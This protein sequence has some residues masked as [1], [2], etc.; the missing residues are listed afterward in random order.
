[1]IEVIR[2]HAQYLQAFFYYQSALFSEL[3]WQKGTFSTNLEPEAWTDSFILTIFSRIAVVPSRT[4]SNWSM[5]CT[6]SCYKFEEILDNEVHKLFQ[7]PAP[8]EQQILIA[9]RWKHFLSL[10]EI[11]AWLCTVFGQIRRHLLTPM[12]DLHP[13]ALNLEQVAVN[14]LALHGWRA[15]RISQLTFL[16]VRGLHVF[17]SYFQKSIGRLDES[18][19]SLSSLESFESNE[20]EIGNP[21]KCQWLSLLAWL[22]W[23]C[24]K[25]VSKKG[26]KIQ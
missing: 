4:F 10:I 9:A 24:N 12:G 26:L 8:F 25:I 20:E 16:G 6:N 7:S 13:L 11:S 17:D 19:E 2:D 1:M 5:D 15:A 14:V 21:Q 23:I 3:I 18:E 22:N